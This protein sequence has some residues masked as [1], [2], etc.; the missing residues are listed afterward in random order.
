M[1]DLASSAQLG[2]SSGQAMGQGQNP[3]G[4]FIRNMLAVH[5]Q[6]Q[7]LA[8]QGAMQMGLSKADTIN[9][10]NAQIIQN[11]KGQTVTGADLTG[12][13]YSYN[14]GSPYTPEEISGA[15]K[16]LG[17]QQPPPQTNP[18]P[19]IQG[20][21]EVGTGMPAG[22]SVVVGGG[23]IKVNTSSVMGQALVQLSKESAEGI[24]KQLQRGEVAGFQSADGRTKGY[25]SAINE[26][27]PPEKRVNLDPLVLG[28]SAEKSMMSDV[29]LQDNKVAAGNA[30]QVLLNSSYDPKTG[31]YV[32][33]PS[34]H[35]EL[36]ISIARL[37]SP[38]GQIAENM[39]NQLQQRTL[40]ENLAGLA[41]WAGLSPKEIGGSTQSVI[42]MFAKV[43][44][45]E[46]LTAMKQRENYLQGQGSGYV[47]AAA[48]QSPIP[49]M[50][51]QGDTTENRYQ[52]YLQI[53]GGK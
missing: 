44:Q 2:F 5:Q 6:N 7:Q 27:L 24:M 43:I 23:K 42:N 13:P 32:V 40:R 10:L 12:K 47:G 52:R 29:K 46:T 31:N 3:M 1:G 37:L 17:M 16:G 41:I 35:K 18:I 11:S 39:V 28:Y 50:Q 26:K 21:N 30:A 38:T 19:G 51:T 48:D 4:E 8:M 49:G 15:Y 22:Q 34:M 9:K 25:V 20:A 14:I 36:A 53:V 45:R 33:P